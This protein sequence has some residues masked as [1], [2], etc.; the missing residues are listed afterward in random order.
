[1]GFQSKAVTFHWTGDEAEF[2]GGAEDEWAAGSVGRAEVADGR[3]KGVLESGVAV[4][5]LLPDAGGGL[6]EPARGGSWCGCR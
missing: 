5:E 4:G 6:P 1:M 3:A 2:A